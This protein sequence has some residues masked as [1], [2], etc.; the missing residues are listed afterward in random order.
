M[1]GALLRLLRGDGVDPREEARQEA[2]R[3]LRLAEQDAKAK[4]LEGQEDALRLRKGDGSGG[5]RAPP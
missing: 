1:W 4:A 2:E 3:I 5:P